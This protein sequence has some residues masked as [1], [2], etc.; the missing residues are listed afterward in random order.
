MS[1]PMGWT[2][3]STKEEGTPPAS[4]IGCKGEGDTRSLGLRVNAANLA[5]ASNL[6]HQP[7]TSLRRTEALLPTQPVGEASMLA[8]GDLCSC[9]CPLGAGGDGGNAVAAPVGEGMFG[10][11]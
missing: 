6:N 1:R 10:P 7:R 4:E 11:A 9:V 2:A 8:L 5:A 3:P